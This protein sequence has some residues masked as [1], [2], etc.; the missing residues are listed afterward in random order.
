M[1]A[2]KPTAMDAAQDAQLNPVVT[3][4]LSVQRAAM[5]ETTPMMMVAI[6]TVPTQLAATEFRL[7]VSS[8][9]MAI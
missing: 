4:S 2:I 5:M 7:A 3:T 8:A 9:T 6:L 1:I